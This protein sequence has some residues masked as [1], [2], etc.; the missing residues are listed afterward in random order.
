MFAVYDRLRALTHI[1]KWIRPLS[2]YRI[3]V[4]GRAIELE[5]FAFVVLWIGTIRSW[6]RCAGAASNRFRVIKVNIC[7]QL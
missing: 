7:K 3:P 6:N 4:P 5:Q 1:H 2:K